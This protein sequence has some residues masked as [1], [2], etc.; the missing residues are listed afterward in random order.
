MVKCLRTLM[1]CFALVLVCRG[2]DLADTYYKAAE[3]A[4]KAGDLLNAYFLYARAAALDPK[5]VTYAAKKTSLRMAANRSVHTDLGPDPAGITDEPPI[6]VRELPSPQ[7]DDGKILL[8]P[9]QLVVSSE[10]KSFNLKGEAEKIFEQ[11][12]GAYG[13]QVIFEADYK[14]P[15]PF[16]FRL[17]DATAEQALR[18]LEL[19]A[20]S[21][22][23]PLN[24]HLALVSRDTDAKRKEH[25]AEVAV[26]IPIAERMSAQDA[27]EM[28][29]AVKS[30]LD[31]RRISLDPQHRQVVLRD[32]AGKVL[33]AQRLFSILSHIRPQIE[34]D[35][36][37]V[38]VD[39]TSSLGYGIGLPNQISVVNFVGS[40]A[41][42]GAFSA[43]EEITG[44]ASPYGVGIGNATVLATLARA[45]ATT[46][47]DAQI[48]AEDGQAATLHVGEKYPIATNQYVG[49]TAGTTGTV[50]TPPPTITF[51]DLGLVM[52]VT[53]SIHED[54]EVT[55]DLETAYKTLGAVS[56]VA[57]I[58]I[59]NSRTY[60]AK[61]RFKEGEWGVI[62]GL[63]QFNDS[64]VRSGWPGLFDVPILGKLFAQNN[65][66]HDS[67]R[68]LV[69]LKPHIIALP[70]WETLAH[71]IWVGTETRPVSVF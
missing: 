51:E 3:K 50:Y 28:L 6:A 66:E 45:S 38:E 5:N 21:F 24:P 17:D 33:A 63:V 19:V 67:T 42:P 37:F 60:N 62:A 49:S 48:L 69:F 55:L 46:L 31:I 56:P 43:L 4:E 13:I 7:K 34:V 61:V 12:A 53:P 29:T 20:N 59:I 64:E 47:L 35:V 68:I 10:K 30:A 41:L 36:E 1:V 23:T 58:P 70:P 15:P 22:L 71:T 14:S 32:E 65:I 27:Q 54:Q 11:V 44:A 25:T 57:G 16:T 39:K 26:T 9:P 8:P 18:G 52:K 40:V 2:S